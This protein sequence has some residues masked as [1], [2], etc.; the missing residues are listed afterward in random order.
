MSSST[1]RCPG[2]T[3]GPQIEDLDNFRENLEK[4]SQNIATTNLLVLAAFTAAVEE[5]VVDV[6]FPVDDTAP[7]L[8]VGDGDL[9]PRPDGPRGRQCQPVVRP[10][11]SLGPQWST[12]IG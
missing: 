7:Q 10:V 5:P 9:L 11:Q 4:I 2:Q 1:A 8:G 3:R 6:L 12:L